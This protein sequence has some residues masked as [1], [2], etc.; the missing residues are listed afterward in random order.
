MNK[1][2]NLLFWTALASV[3]ACQV[4]VSRLPGD[5]HVF[6]AQIASV[7]AADDTSASGSVADE[8]Q[9]LV[10]KMKAAVIILLAKLG[11]DSEAARLYA[12]WIVGAPALVVL[13]LLLMIFRPW[14]RRTLVQNKP[15]RQ[16]K[17]AP[18]SKPNPSASPVPVP[19]TQSEPAS[20][21]ERV[22]NFFFYLFRKQVGAD[23]NSPT[24]LVLIETRPTCPNETY[25]MRIL[26]GNEWSSRRMSIGLLGQ[27]GGSRSKCFYVI[28]DSHMVLKIPSQPIPHFSKYHQQ[29]ADEARIVSRL[30]PRECIVP[31]ISV[32][33]KAIQFIPGN[34]KLSEDELE[35][36]YV[37]LLKHDPTYQKYLKIGP[38]FAFFMDLAKHFFLSSTL[39][40]IHRGSQR[41]VI[42]ALKHHELLWDQHGFVC[43]YGEEA[44]LVC[45]ALQDAYYRAE[46]RMRKLAE[47]ARVSEKVST[48]EFK[49]WF[50]THLAGENIDPDD[51]QLPHELIERINR[52][53]YKVIKKNY[54]NVELYRKQVRAY[55]NE[56]RFSQ[57]RSQIENLAANTLDLL[58]W[59]GEKGLAMRD[60]KP[61]NLFVAGNPETYPL[62]LNDCEQ[63]SI[64]LIDVET[65]VVI[66]AQ[67]ID[68][69]P[70]PQLAG[71]P[72]Y[73][74]P[75]HLFTNIVIQQIYGDLRNIL[76]LQDWYSTIAIIY[77]IICGENL[78]STT[79][80]VFPE[81]IKR[82]KVIDPTGPD[83]DQDI[84]RISRI[85][86]NSSQA[87]FKEALIRK[88]DLFTRVE[89][90][91]P[92][93]LLPDIIE[94][95]HHDSD[96]LASSLAKTVSEQTIFS[97][98]EKCQFLMNA[99]AEKII[100]MKNKLGR[101]KKFGDPASRK[102]REQ[103]MDMLTC[104]E[105]IKSRLESKLQAAAALKAAGRP[106]EAE[107]L[108]DAMFQ[109]VFSAMYLPRWPALVP[110]KW[111]GT[112]DLPADI[113]TYQATM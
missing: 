63:F 1:L 23:S 58:A 105:Q 102:R 18:R 41:L 99:P 112:A 85:F 26:Q 107:Q 7:A 51:N 91:V 39:E 32:I 37:Q 20:D 92:E 84:A 31:R 34:E 68:Q 110:E 66:D 74:T 11:V 69:I 71:T 109:R 108:L 43:R 24:Q 48:F 30:T 70:Q 111:R 2:V 9:E 55:I 88:H 94:T 17:P 29:I 67:D 79:A 77:K 59:I 6:S 87:E 86:W 4:F 61:E 8:S 95:L 76:H 52:L 50:V 36:R 22:L 90:K 35:D 62:F 80:R 96:S 10:S 78:F 89:V 47:E 25:E 103:A 113:T 73:A 53:M 49:Q 13:I 97:G 54:Q 40:E 83:L 60:L 81:I 98:K 56:T 65:S 42:E 57:H 75:A 104:I 72:L 3:L 106:I 14:R 45:H 12:K 28:Y 27:G 93:S 38:S 15:I 44:G 64:G 21:K 82:I 100:K 33:L 101:E 46:S 5:L 16:S 19:E